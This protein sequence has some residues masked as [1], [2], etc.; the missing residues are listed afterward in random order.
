[1]AGVESDDQYGRSPKIKVGNEL[2][3]STVSG[4]VVQAGVIHGDINLGAGPGF[5]PRVPQQLPPPPTHFTNRE[6]ELSALD[7]LLD[8]VTSRLAPEVVV[9]TGFAGVGKTA[10]TLRWAAAHRDRF[11]GGQL[12][13]DLASVVVVEPVSVSRTLGAF[14]RSAGFPPHQ[15]PA[16]ESERAALWRS[17]TAQRAVLVVLDNAHSAAQVRG[18]IPGSAASV[19][20]VTSR[21]RLAGLAQGGARTI[22][23]VP[24]DLRSGLELLRRSI[25]GPRVEREPDQARRL[26]SLCGGLP[27]AVCVAAAQLSSRPVRSIQGAVRDLSR[28]G[29]RLTA[30]SQS[31]ELSVRAVFDSSFHDLPAEP[32]RLYRLASLHPGDAFSSH[33]AAVLA[34]APVSVVT[35]LIDV[36]V[37]ANLLQ[38]TSEDRYQF[39]DLVRQHAHEQAEAAGEADSAA[40]APMRICEWYLRAARAAVLAATGLR[41]RKAYTFTTTAPTF[42]LPE[43]LESVDGSW[44]WLDVEQGNIVAAL[45]SAGSAGRPELAWHLADVTRPLLRVRKDFQ[46]AQEVEREGLAAARAWGERRAERSMLKRLARSCSE[47]GDYAQAEGYARKALRLAEA[48]QDSRGAT[49]A[50]KALTLLLVDQGQYAEAESRLREIVDSYRALGRIRSRAT[51]EITLGAVLL[52]LR[53]PAEAVPFLASSVELLSDLD[54]PDEYNLARARAQLGQARAALG[55][56]EVAAALLAAALAVLVRLGSRFEQALVHEALADL[57]LARGDVFGARRHL[58][59][60]ATLLRTLGSVQADRIADKIEGMD[61]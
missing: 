9:V 51:T 56:L 16:D 30:L 27:I 4:G 23:V 45:K 41:R 44:A 52:A 32:A 28:R 5:E 34:D 22:E 12:F 15:I 60:A 54:P 1:M 20:L 17:W 37:D 8:P 3:G 42:A 57:D 53:Q 11:T 61:S 49:S 43:E 7:L 46:L 26:V 29:S 58:T 48:D 59:T 55:D 14:L 6:A 50:R 35:R 21:K 25:G 47:L 40:T 2:A 31:E 10:L 33:A 19:V 38:E 36:L 39:H 18:L 24:L 13:A